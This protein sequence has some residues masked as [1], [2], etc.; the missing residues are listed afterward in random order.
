MDNSQRVVSIDALR[1]FDM[2]WLIGAHSVLL[3][4]GT[5]IGPQVSAALA[6]QLDHSAWV[7]FTF[8]DFIAPLFL[9]VVGLSMPY[10]ISKRLERG[11]SRSDLYKHI[12]KRTAVLILLGW[13]MNGWL[14]L[15][16]PVRLSGVLA[17]IALSYCIAALIVMRSNWRGQMLWTAGLLLG[18]WALMAWVPVPG[19]GAGVYT[20]EG[21]LS[22]FLDRTLIPGKRCCAEYAQYGDHSGILGTFPAAASVLA[23][24]LCGHLLRSAVAPARKVAVFVASGAACVG[25]GSLWGMFLPISTALWSSSYTLF[26]AGWSMLLYALFYWVIDMRGYRKWAFPFIVIGMNALTI[27][28][29]QRLIKFSDI[30]GIVMKGVIRHSG[31]FADLLTAASTLAV[32]WL[33]LLWLYKKKVF[34]RV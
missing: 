15:E 6:V 17:R 31:Q 10:S 1:G 12:F 9:F 33:F 4:A 34:W 7:G 23:G 16:F 32:E 2:L 27:Y 26:A 22:G 28:V 21:N 25:V 14:A 30:A 19:Y 18:Y 5:L 11:D 3:A 13:L 8:W 24:V 20:P 29:L